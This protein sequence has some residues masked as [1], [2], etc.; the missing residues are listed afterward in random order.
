M[1]RVLTVF[2]VISMLWAPGLAYAQAETSDIQAVVDQ[3]TADF[4]AGRYSEALEGYQQARE[5]G[6]PPTLLFMIGRCHQSG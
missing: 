4:E 1:L 5:A 3:A 2:A 6:G